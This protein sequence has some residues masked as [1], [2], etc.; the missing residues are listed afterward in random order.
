MVSS[1]NE[2]SRIISMLRVN[3]QA[4]D[5]NVLS[6]KARFI[7]HHLE[8]FSLEKSDKYDDLMIIL[9]LIRLFGLHLLFT[10]SINSFVC[11][12]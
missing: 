6:T 7:H 1:L 9:L 12:H 5:T 4:L 11:L 2:E 8:N 10:L 3:T